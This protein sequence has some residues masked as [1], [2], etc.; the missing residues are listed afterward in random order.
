MK[1]AILGALVLTA[2]AS[3]SSAVAAPEDDA[4]SRAAQ[5]YK[6]GVAA[7][8]RGDLQTAAREL[9]LA[10]AIAPNPVALRAALDAA[11]DADDPALGAELIER[12]R[13][14]PAS[15]PL[16]ASLEAAKKKFAG[17]AGRVRVACPEGASCLATIDGTKLVVGATAWTR[18]G[19]HTI[20]V[21]VDGVAETKLVDV[22]MAEEV[23]VS[24]TPPAPPPAVTPAPA[25]APPAVPPAS[26]SPPP[27]PPKA[28]VEP[29]P[30]MDHH[31][32]LSPTLIWVGA[33]ITVAAG[34]FA[35]VFALQTKGAHEDFVAASC[36]T[37]PSSD[38]DALK[39]DGEGKQ[40]R[41]NVMLGVAG[42]TA[43]VT[44][45][46]AVLWTDWRGD[47]RTGGAFAAPVASGA[48]AGWSGRF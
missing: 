1:R 24:P 8:D 4:R 36:P 10:D 6:R 31:K 33:G 2:L 46:A 12:A 27:P 5:A 35:T 26:E 48:V 39:D 23:V 25:A 22:G 42:A 3:A 34:A 17:R 15:G 40:T 7:H 43:A 38:C 9:A 19:Q 11:I 14:A 45:L 16:A 13:R 29:A 20:V 37:R 28:T 41:T 47:H 21:Q 18:T 44:V 30:E 32:P